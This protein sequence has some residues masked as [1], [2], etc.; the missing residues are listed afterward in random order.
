MGALMTRNTSIVLEWLW[1][2]WQPATP[3]SIICLSDKKQKQ[4][5]EHDC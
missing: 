5:P 1:L 2:A 3:I 4:N